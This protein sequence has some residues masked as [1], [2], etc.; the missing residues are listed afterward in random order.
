MAHKKV[1]L[2]EKICLVC[3]RPFKWRKKWQ[4]D[5]DSVKYCSQRCRQNKS[6]KPN[7]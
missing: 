3:S 6:T 4:K 2:P 5:W 7:N 1:N